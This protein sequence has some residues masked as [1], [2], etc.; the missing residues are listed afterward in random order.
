MNTYLLFPGI[1][2]KSG[3]CV[4]LPFI[5]TPSQASQMVNHLD[6][7][8]FLPSNDSGQRMEPALSYSPAPQSKWEYKYFNLIEEI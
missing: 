4:E 2:S 1:G 3:T 8:D 7:F 6:I 5:I